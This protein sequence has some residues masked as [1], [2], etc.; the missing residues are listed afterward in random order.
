[1]AKV[2]VKMLVS[3]FVGGGIHATEGEILEV[4]DATYLIKKGFAVEVAAPKPGRPKGSKNKK[5]TETKTPEGKA[6][7]KQTPAPKTPKVKPVPYPELKAK[8]KALGI[9]IKGKRADIEKAIAEAEKAN[10]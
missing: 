3:C 4:A 6:P 9:P 7:E 5:E 1:M 8:A 2:K 10:Q